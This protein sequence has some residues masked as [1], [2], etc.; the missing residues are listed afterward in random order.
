MMFVFEYIKNTFVISVLTITAFSVAP[1]VD[2]VSSKIKQ[3]NQLR[4]AVQ[5][6]SQT[7]KSVI[8][9]VLVT[10]QILKTTVIIFFNK[11]FYGSQCY[12]KNFYLVEYF[13]N[14]SWYYI[15][16]ISKRGPKPIITLA[17]TKE[18]EYTDFI[19]KVA[20]PNVDFYNLELSPRQLGIEAE[21]IINVDGNEKKFNPDEII[22][23]N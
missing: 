5:E 11:L 8:N 3:I 9:S 10:F 17:Y 7:N 21:L 4:L 2:Y 16:V 1:I 19:K 15:P 13:H 6:T 12:S 23:I 20:G 14:T 18:S 22:N